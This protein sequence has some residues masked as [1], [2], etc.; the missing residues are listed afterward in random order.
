MQQLKLR[1]L[2]LGIIAILTVT[3]LVSAYGSS[4]SQSGDMSPEAISVQ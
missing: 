3:L 1:R 4:G 2:A